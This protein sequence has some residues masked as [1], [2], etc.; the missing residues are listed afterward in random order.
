MDTFRLYNELSQSLSPEAARVMAR[1]L[2]D[3]YEELRQTVTKSDFAELKSVVADLAQAQQRTEQRVEELAQAQQRTEQ[4]LQALAEA[5]RRTEKEVRTLARG[6]EQTR[7]MVGGLSDAVGYG[8]EDRAMAR[9]PR[10]LEEEQGVQ[11]EGRLIRR[12]VEYPDGGMDEV[13][14]L[15]EGRRGES[16]ISIVG[17]AKARLGKR[18]VDRFLKLVGRL[19]AAGLLRPERLLLV[20]TYSLR[21][22]IERY[23]RTQGLV[24]I[25]SYLLA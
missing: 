19:E 3:M 11:V 20:V 12:F 25:P 4:R 18:D 9:L 21:P 22:E 17:E 7:E 14:I 23:A 24:P 5:Q 6:L 8:L 2:G 10:L 15:G 16:D 13:N 1:V